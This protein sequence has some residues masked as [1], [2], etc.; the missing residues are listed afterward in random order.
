MATVNEKMTAL[1]DAIREKTGET[2]RLSLDG[3]IDSLNN[4]SGATL[5][6]EVIGGT[7]QPSSPKNNTI[8][9]NTSTSITSWNLS[10]DQPSNPVNGMV[11]IAISYNAKTTF[12]LIENNPI[13]ISLASCYQYTSN[14]WVK[15]VSKIYKNNTWV[16]LRLH[17]YDNGDQCSS[18]TGGWQT[19]NSGGSISFQSTGV[20][21]TGT[22]S[23]GT[24]IY[25]KNT[26]DFTP[27]STMTIIGNT[28][29][30]VY[31]TG[32]QNCGLAKTVG[33]V[34][35]GSWGTGTTGK[36]T[37]NVDV[38]SVTGKYYIMA[39]LGISH[40]CAGYIYEIYLE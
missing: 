8:W 21:L 19:Y 24:Y 26:I 16:P 6:F 1:A 31:N 33:T 7:T 36:F 39:G 28:T 12:N 9:V 11:W 22:T 17:V 5:N 14:K 35:A 2:G 37:I 29:S 23:G 34:T 38:S 13:T 27:Y 4:Y 40:Q 10:V 3:M 15:K 20:Q 32:F 18:I 25:T 30:A